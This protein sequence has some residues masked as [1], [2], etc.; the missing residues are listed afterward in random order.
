[1]LSRADVLQLGLPALAQ[2]GNHLLQ[3][4]DFPRENAA[5]ATPNKTHINNQEFRTCPGPTHRPIVVPFWDYLIKILNVNLKKEL[6]WGL[7]VTL[8]QPLLRAVSWT[9][10]KRNTCRLAL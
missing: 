9:N 7:W 6:L 2:V 4:L 1:M 3:R 8:T 10:Q 5:N